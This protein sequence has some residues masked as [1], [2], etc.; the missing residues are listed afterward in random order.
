MPVRIPPVLASFLDVMQCPTCRACLRPDRGTLRC[1]ARHTFDISRHGVVSLLTGARATSGD[2]PAMARA[3]ERFLASGKYGRIRRTV[4]HL[5]AGAT[6]DKHTVVDVGCGT[7]YYLS[8]VLDHLPDARGLGL[9]S[10][11]RALR[12]TARAHERALAASWDVFRPLPLVDGAADVVL[13]VF[14]P[15]NPPEFHRVLHPSGRLVVVRPTGRHLREL[16]SL[17]PGM[18][19]V[20][21]AKEH[22][23]HGALA[24]H[25]VADSTE[26]IEH[27]TSLTRSEALDL[28]GMTPSARHLDD[29]DLAAVGL[30]LEHVTVS[31]LATAYRPR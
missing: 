14:A 18:V 9:D 3:R 11:V 1:P 25:F 27:H 19:A 2:D 29:H 4:A 5:A 22:R 30:D 10:S 12:A 7:G 17:V 24:A 28:V 6:L 8:G 15:R 31:V 16:R 23:L 21:P 26:P 20:D 13:D